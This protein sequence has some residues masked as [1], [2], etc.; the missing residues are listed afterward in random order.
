MSE[1]QA[2]FIH[3]L[4]IPPM[5]PASTDPRQTREEQGLPPIDR[6]W[7]ETTLAERQAAL[8]LKNAADSLYGALGGF[9]VT[10]ASQRDVP[11]RRQEARD[12]LAVLT[13]ESKARRPALRRVK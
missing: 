3:D 12:A 9:L 5:P 4:A 2:P 13:E 11:R 6:Q 10:P 8:A 7:L 1:P